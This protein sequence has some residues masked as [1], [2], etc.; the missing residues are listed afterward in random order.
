MSNFQMYSVIWCLTQCL[1]FLANHVQEMLYFT[2]RSTKL[3]SNE[4]KKRN[5]LMSRHS[6]TS[7]TDH[8][9]TI[10][11]FFTGCFWTNYKVNNFHIRDLQTLQFSGKYSVS[12]SYTFK[13]VTTLS[14][15]CHLLSLPQQF[16]FHSAAVAVHGAARGNPDSTVM[17]CFK[18]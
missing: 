12:I 15:C 17:C 6:L 1:T 18:N 5:S 3:I 8:Q 9:I 10:L 14:K 13:N 7:L 16:L 11:T 2:N 4:D